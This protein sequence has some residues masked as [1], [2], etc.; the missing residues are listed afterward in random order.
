MYSAL[1]GVPYTGSIKWEIM[2]CDVTVFESP[3]E[4]LK[5]EIKRIP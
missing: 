4:T 1:L 3:Q 2:E 5:L